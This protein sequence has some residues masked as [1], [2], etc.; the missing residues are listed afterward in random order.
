MQNHENVLRHLYIHNLVQDL[1]YV[2]PNMLNRWQFHMNGKSC[3]IK[4]HSVFQSRAQQGMP[5]PYFWD[6]FLEGFTLKPYL[7][8]SLAACWSKYCCGLTEVMQSLPKSGY[9]LS[10]PFGGRG[11]CQSLVRGCKKLGVVSAQVVWSS[12]G[13][14]VVPHCY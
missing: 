6:V 5:L 10:L 7:K 4:F 12:A 2:R 13:A 11:E 1:K 14:A 8:F 3:P 9:Q